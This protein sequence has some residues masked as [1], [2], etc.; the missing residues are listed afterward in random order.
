MRNLLLSLLLIASIAACA[1]A[2]ESTPVPT[3]SLIPPTPTFTPSPVPPTLTP[4]PGTLT[5][6]DEVVQPAPTAE[7]LTPEMT[8]ERLTGEAL[9]AQ[10]AIAAELVGMAQ[11]DVAEALDLPTRRVRVVDVRPVVWTD[12]S[13]NCPLPDQVVTEMEID[14]YRI[15]LEAADQ[16]Y[17]FHT[18]VDRVVPCNPVNEKLPPDVFP[19]EEATEE[20]E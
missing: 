11:R 14:G 10:D 4:V 12:T 16:E 13:L 17:L 1:P 15:V 3:A 18:D 6:P 2:A 7:S 20:A 8:V 19:A 9:L 5:A